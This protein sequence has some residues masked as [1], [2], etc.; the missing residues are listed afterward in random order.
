MNPAYEITAVIASPERSRGVWQSHNFGAV[1]GHAIGFPRRP[2]VLVLSVVE[3]SGLL[4]MTGLVRRGSKTL[5]GE[6]FSA[7]EDQSPD[8]AL[9][10]GRSYY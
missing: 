3:G 4:G 1:M 10:Q 7:E 2:D 6:P 8:W 9:I 5:Q